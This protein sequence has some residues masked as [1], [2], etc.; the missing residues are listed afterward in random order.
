MAD[1]EWPG[2]VCRHK[3]HVDDLTGKLG[4]RSVRLARLHDGLNQ[5]AGT[6][7]LQ[8]D[9]DKPGARDLGGLD[10]VVGE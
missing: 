2:G 5:F 1:V 7:G 6:A 10:S 9:V 3:L 4:A 8:G